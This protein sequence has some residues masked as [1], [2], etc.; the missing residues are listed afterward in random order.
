MYHHFGAYWL[1]KLGWNPFP[2]IFPFYSHHMDWNIIWIYHGFIWPKMRLIHENHGYSH[3]SCMPLPSGELTCCHGKSPCLMGKSTIHMAMFN[4]LLYVHQRVNPIKIPLNPIK[5]QFSYG[6]PMVF[7]WFSYD[8]Y[9]YVHWS[10]ER[11]ENHG[12]PPCSEVCSFATSVPSETA[13]WQ[14]PRDRQSCSGHV[15]EGWTY[16]TRLF[17]FHT[18]RLWCENITNNNEDNIIYI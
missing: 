5:P 16:F 3:E 4:S 12:E 8:S 9:G 1:S 11:W 2:M 17:F 13:S 18:M 15:A 7:L 6:F 10:H 14:P